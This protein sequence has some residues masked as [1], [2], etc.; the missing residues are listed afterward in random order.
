MSA[1]R[2]RSSSILSVRTW[3]KCS[4][5]LS[6]FLKAM[7]SGIFSKAPYLYA[8]IMYSEVCRNKQLKH[9]LMMTEWSSLGDSVHNVLLIRMITYIFLVR[10][11]KPEGE[12]TRLGSSS[13]LAQRL[14]IAGQQIPG[15]RQNQEIIIRFCTLNWYTRQ[16]T[17]IYCEF[18]QNNYKKKKL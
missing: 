8:W 16:Y 15:Q 3:A 1:S 4:E 14:C 2:K 12:V 13:K 5:W 10:V 9:E 17:F 6:R 18:K 11:K 7:N